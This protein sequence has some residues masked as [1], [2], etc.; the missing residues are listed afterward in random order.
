MGGI[1]LMAACGDD[2]ATETRATDLPTV[3]VTTN[4][5][6]DVVENLVG[7]QAEVVT[8]MPVGAS[9]HE[10]Q[11]SARE[12]AAMRE[13]ELL[14]VNG[15]GFEEGLLE[16]ISAA[17]DDGVAVYEATAVLP[18]EDD[19]HAAEEGDEHGHEGGDP[20]FF[21]DPVSMAEAAEGIVDQLGA[22]IPGFDRAPAD[23]YLAELAELHQYVEGIVAPI[24]A[25]RRVLVTNHEVMSYFA[26]RYGFEIVGTVIPGG[27]TSEG[28][29]AGELAELAGV[30]TA[31]EV[32]AIFVDT[33]SPADLA[34]TLAKEVG[35]EVQVVELFSESLGE[36]GS[37]AATYV[38][39]I[40][41][42]AERIAEALGG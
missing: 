23:T 27:S 37:G 1:V 19:D 2:G 38:E 13:A 9:P 39:M 14:I 6:G 11:A 31:R 40:R 7:D 16:V 25:D 20:H 36:A 10:F 22:T 5:V 24:P 35:G 33:S 41:T 8:I 12:A 28:T 42:N 26:E 15:R 21:S 34:A 18:E 4:I 17:R 29:S 3:V 30:I 32:P